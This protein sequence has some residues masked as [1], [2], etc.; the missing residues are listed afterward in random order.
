M[1]VHETNSV[2]GQGENDAGNAVPESCVESEEELVSPR[3]KGDVGNKD[4][5]E[6]DTEDG[7]EFNIEEVDLEDVMYDNSKKGAITK[8]EKLGPVIEG[9]TRRTVASPK[10]G[11]SLEVEKM[12]P[13]ISPDKYDTEG[14]RKD[15]LFNL[16]RVSVNGKSLE[17]GLVIYQ[18]FLAV[19]KEKPDYVAVAAAFKSGGSISFTSDSTSKAIKKCVTSGGENVD[20]FVIAGLIP[21]GKLLKLKKPDFGAIISGCH[22]KN[23]L[24][25]MLLDRVE[26][27]TIPSNL[28]YIHKLCKLERGS[29][30]P[31]PSYR[32]LEYDQCMI[33]IG[34][35]L[36]WLKVLHREKVDLKHH[37]YF[38]KGLEHLNRILKKF[39]IGSESGS[40]EEEDR[41]GD[42]KSL[43]SND[44]EIISLKQVVKRMQNHVQHMDKEMTSFLARTNS[45]SG[46]SKAVTVPKG[47]RVIFVDED[48]YN[49]MV[50]YYQFR[51]N[52]GKRFKPMEK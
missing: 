50:D 49:E 32:N 43:E 28:E 18:K 2:T 40:D 45:Q 34:R 16:Y 35:Y 14:G 31:L 15:A 12:K 20:L 22:L 10:A 52:S 46:S 3:E 13:F 17:T 30:S 19:V 44:K 47:K 24:P 27:R 25:L 42:V 4:D 11:R 23:S 33:Y 41:E 48:H 21:S 39:D 37:S 8:K 36:G 26:Q 5:D 51:F 9:K 7:G 38:V 29:I 6:G 1:A